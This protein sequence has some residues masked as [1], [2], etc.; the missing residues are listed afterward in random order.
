MII[1]NYGQLEFVNR[2]HMK[3]KNIEIKDLDNETLISAHK[4]VVG[5]Q[6][7]FDARIESVKTLPE[8]NRKKRLSKIFEKYPVNQQY[9]EL[10]NE[11]DNEIKN[12][13]LVV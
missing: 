2:Y 3:W 13:G 4:Y 5:M 7:K 9:V 1:I 6:E 11:I 8:S 10:V 12:R